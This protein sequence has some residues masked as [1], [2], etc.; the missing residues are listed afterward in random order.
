LTKAK[1]A[2][3]RPLGA[4]NKPKKSKDNP[5]PAGTSSVESARHASDLHARLEDMLGSNSS[6]VPKG[7]PGCSGGNKNQASLVGD[8]SRSEE[9]V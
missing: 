8:G 7:C 5:S 2:P 1:R 6:P 4:K 9:V 3:G